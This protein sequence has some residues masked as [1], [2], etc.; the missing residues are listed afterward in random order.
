MV[1]PGDHNANDQVQRH[2]DEPEQPHVL[3]PSPLR[4]NAWHTTASKA[5]N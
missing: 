4:D 1:I 5:G 2:Q 3:L